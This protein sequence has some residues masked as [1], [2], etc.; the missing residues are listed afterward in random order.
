MAAHANHGVNISSQDFVFS[1][2][3]IRE[4][5]ATDSNYGVYSSTDGRAQQLLQNLTRKTNQLPLPQNV[6]CE[7]GFVIV[8]DQAKLTTPNFQVRATDESTGESDTED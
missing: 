3:F 5:I 2:K 1:S 7:P 8:K 6:W 4:A